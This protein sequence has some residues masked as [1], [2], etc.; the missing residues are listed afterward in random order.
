MV[1][2]DEVARLRELAGQQLGTVLALNVNSS[3]ALRYAVEKVALK[4]LE[5]LLP[6]SA[7]GPEPAAPT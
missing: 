6:E 7:G 5:D 4:G 3:F 2:R 1:L